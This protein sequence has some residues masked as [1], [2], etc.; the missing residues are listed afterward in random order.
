MG[1]RNTLQSYFCLKKGTATKRA[2]TLENVRGIPPTGPQEGSEGEGRGG[3]G[4]MKS[5]RTHAETSRKQHPRA[6]NTN[7]R[8]FRFRLALARW[9]LQYEHRARYEQQGTPRSSPELHPQLFVL[10]NSKET[11][12][13]KNI[14]WLVIDVPDT[15]RKGRVKPGTAQGSSWENSIRVQCR[16]IEDRQHL[17]LPP[18]VNKIIRVV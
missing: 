16:P 2:P 11:T 7:L 6:Y 8:L 12:H 4:G 5:S 15:A 9:L 10:D 1:P 13:K 17:T 14:E 18:W 3:E